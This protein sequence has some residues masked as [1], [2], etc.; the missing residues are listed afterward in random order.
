MNLKQISGKLAKIFLPLL[1]GVALFW[2]LY[3]KSDMTTIVAIIKKGVDYK[4]LLSSL[5]F[6]L[7]ANMIRGFRWAM[8]I[9]S[10]GKPVKKKNAIYAVLGNY[11]INIAIPFRAGEIWRCGIMTK[12]ENIS[13]T[14]LLGT[15]FVDRF[16][17]TL[18]VAMLTLCLF[19]FNIS[20]FN[21]FF[22]ENPP[23]IIDT[24]YKI[25][26]SVWTY[27]GIFT[28]IVLIWVL[29]TKFNHLLIIQKF[30]E[31][32][33]NVLDGIKSVLKIKHK[34][35]FLLQT[36]LIW[37]GYFAYFYISFYAFDFTKDLGIRIGL[38]AFV[39]GSLGVA[40]PVQ[41]GIGVWH[42]MVITTLVT[43]GVNKT[44]ADAFA[45]VVFAIQSIWIVVTGLFGII[46]LP[47]ANKKKSKQIND[48]PFTHI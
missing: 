38:I 17:D 43:F 8:L 14:K 18:I 5:I 45:F 36:L 4:I 2:F 30:K 32:I 12:Y 27:L 46:A 6:G 28:A 24:F 31:L 19:V 7:A 47:L 40:V 44:D 25:I 11:A 16:M 23:L 48:I 34:T 20:F 39:M 26:S 13:F 1:L 22:S 15:L 9:D 41:G 3:H 29:L 42:F 21:N 10:L 33:C 37:G 35:L